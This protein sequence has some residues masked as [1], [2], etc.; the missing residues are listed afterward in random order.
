MASLFNFDYVTP[1]TIKNNEPRFITDTQ[2]LRRQSVRTGAQRWELDISF[3]GGKHDNLYGVFQAHFMEYGLETPFYIPMPQNQAAKSRYN[4]EGTI[5][6][7]ANTV[8]A[9][10]AGDNSVNLTSDFDFTIPAGWFI[11]FESHDKVYMTTKEVSFT[12]GGSP[13]NL[14]I[15]PA[16]QASARPNG[17]TTGVTSDEALAESDDGVLIKVKHEVTNSTVSYTEGYM[18]SVSWSFVES[19]S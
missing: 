4:R 19:L 8:G 15:A 9:N 11:K 1:V 17:D 14:T 6:L 7:S 3:R 12:A 16:L 13:V 2:S 10:S 18:Q 5:E